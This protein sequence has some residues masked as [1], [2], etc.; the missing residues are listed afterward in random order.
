MRVAEALVFARALGVA[1]LDAQLLLAHHLQRERTWLLAHDDAAIDDAA[2][3][4]FQADLHRRAD[5][6]PLSHLTGHREFHGLSL[7]VGPDVLVPRPET[8][9]L[10]DWALEIMRAQAPSSPQQQVADLG[11]GSGAIALAIKRARTGVQVE[12]VDNS[13]DALNVAR[14]NA[15]RLSLDVTFRQASWLAGSTD[16]YDLIVA[17][18]PYVAQDDPHLAALTHEPLAALAA[19]PD[20]LADIRSIVAQATTRLAASGC[21]L[22]EHGWDQ[23][24]TVR[25]LLT[26]AGF[27][28]VTSRR[29]LAGVERCSGGTWPELG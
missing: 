11:T 9:G 6:V 1:R 4:A 25:A 24:P 3:N 20:G 28:A 5:D 10:V 22:L 17:N 26:A 29:D 12:A 18:P 8:E 16:F 23:A 7:Q 14:L 27:R 15:R 21:L 19:G 2:L 13:A